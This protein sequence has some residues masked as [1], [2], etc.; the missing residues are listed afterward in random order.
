MSSGQ[1]SSSEEMPFALSVLEGVTGGHDGLPGQRVGAPAPPPPRRRLLTVEEYV[2]GVRSGDRSILAR[3]ITLIESNAPAHI[4]L[5]QE[6]LRELLPYT[7]GS[8]RVGITGVPGVGK[9]TFIEALGTMLCDRGHRVAV[10]AV[11]PSSSISRGSILGD[12]TRMER[13]A[14][15]PNAYIRPSPTGGS[16]GGVARKSRETLLICEAAGFDIVLVETVGVGQSEIAVRGMVDF[17]LLLMLAGAGDELQGIKKGIIELA[18]ALLITKADGDNRTRALAAQAEY[19]RA[20][21]YLTPATE[22]WR[23]RAYICSAQTGEGIAE[24]WREIERFRDET[25]A[26]GVFAARRREQARDWVYTLIE[27]HLRT[28]FFGHPVVQERL[29]A[30]E[31]AVVEGT[32]PVT[33][34]VQDLIRAFESALQGGEKG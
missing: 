3:A 24:I 4:S 17:F 1:Q 9:S 30:I 21:R 28:R 14:H 18:D 11:D 32:L 10:L 20:L 12:K 19:S 13:L 6:V 2:A 16:L 26:S 29:P 15:H 27:D 7:G 22:G 8:L 25:T 23:P 5:A 33:T 34:A 31:K